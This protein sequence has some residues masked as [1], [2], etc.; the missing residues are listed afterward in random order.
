MNYKDESF[1][2][3]Q[4][5][6]KI[7]RK[8]GLDVGYKQEEGVVEYVAPDDTPMSEEIFKYIKT[9]Y[10]GCKCVLKT[11]RVMVYV[12]NHFLERKA[13]AT[14]VVAALQMKKDREEGAE[15]YALGYETAANKACDIFN[16]AIDAMGEVF[17]D[18]TC[19]IKEQFKKCLFEDPIKIND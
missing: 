8:Y 16:K 7:R 6:T 19:D 12:E 13:E 9:V 15:W 3:A 10:K 1:S 18:K 11:D 17:G 2:I 5:C 14:D 4:L